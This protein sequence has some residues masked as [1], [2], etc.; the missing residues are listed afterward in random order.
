M[1][2]IAFDCPKCGSA[3]VVSERGAG[4]S[5]PCPECG[6]TIVIPSKVALPVVL[7]PLNKYPEERIRFY[8][9]Y[10]NQPLSAPADQESAVIDCPSCHQSV[11]V[12]PVSSPISRPPVSNQI[13]IHIHSQHSVSKKIVIGFGEGFIWGLILGCFGWIVIACKQADE[14]SQANIGVL[15]GWL[16]WLFVLLPTCD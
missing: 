10:C 16:V 11:I 12:P 3:L 15:C 7:P 4:C 5:V 1:S 2:D 9:E 14:K 13:H 6:Q 8:C